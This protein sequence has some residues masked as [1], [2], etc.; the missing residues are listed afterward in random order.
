MI[1]LTI[2]VIIKVETKMII[3]I[4]TKWSRIWIKENNQKVWV[5]VTLIL[6]GS[7]VYRKYYRNQEAADQSYQVL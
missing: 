3:K 2:R 1:R 4:I 7:I 5:I 6:I